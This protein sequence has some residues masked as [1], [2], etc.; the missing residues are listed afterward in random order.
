MDNVLSLPEEADGLH[1]AFFFFRI[2]MN[3]MY[4]SCLQWV[5]PKSTEALRKKA[6]QKNPRY[7]HWLCPH[8]QLAILITAISQTAK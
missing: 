3:N 1:I 2:N 7:T 5:L 8:A 6:S 4:F